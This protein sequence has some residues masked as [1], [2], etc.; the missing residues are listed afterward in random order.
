MSP[1]EAPPKPA[2]PIR[3]AAATTD[4]RSAF[5]DIAMTPAAIPNA[6]P[7]YAP[8]WGFDKDNEGRA[9]R[10]TASYERRCNRNDPF[11]AW[12]VD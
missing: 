9:E 8:A 10:F 2:S 3:A 11:S 1:S 5:S 6:P 7:T 12:I 4:S